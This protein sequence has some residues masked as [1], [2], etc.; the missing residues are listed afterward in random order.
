VTAVARAA[1]PDAEDADARPRRVF[2]AL[3]YRLSAPFA[4]GGARHAVAAEGVHAPH[5]ALELGLGTELGT[6]ATQSAAAG[7]V[8]LFD[9]PVW[10][11]ARL[12][13]RA[14]GRLTLGAGGFAAAHLLWATAAATGG[15][16]RA[17]SFTVAAGAGAEA[18]ARARLGRALGAEIRVF[19]EAALPGTRYWV[20]DVPVLERGARFGAGLGLVFPGP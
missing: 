5:R 2:A 8:S 18:L 17:A 12:V 4:G 20:R 15:A 19:A 7:S 1:A 6:R 3:G 9:L 14:G 13:W 16:E 10:A 11:S